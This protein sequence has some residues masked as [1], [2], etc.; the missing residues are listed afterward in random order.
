MV[1]WILY[2]LAGVTLLYA[3]F[4][5]DPAMGSPFFAVWYAISA[6][7]FGCA[8]LSSHD[9]W[10]I[11]PDWLLTCAIIVLV[12]LVILLGAAG[13]TILSAFHLKAPA[14][15]DVLIEIGRASCRERV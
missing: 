12:I 8:W 7:L 3:V 5:S 2:L 10:G 1:V 9:M 14:D 6:L 13:L 15:L 11:I 4:L